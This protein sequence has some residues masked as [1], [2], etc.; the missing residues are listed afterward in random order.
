MLTIDAAM[1]A[2]YVGIHI[3]IDR[4]IRLRTKP[5]DKADHCNCPI[6]NFQFLCSNISAAP[7]VYISMLMRYSSVCGSYDDL[8]DRGML[9]TTNQLNQGLIVIILK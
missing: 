2:S 7:G 1:S 6:V 3:P 5:Y 4:N 9:L 8:F